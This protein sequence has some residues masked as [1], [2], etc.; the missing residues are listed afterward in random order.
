MEV[1]AVSLSSWEHEILGRIAKELSGSDPKLTSLV[2]GFNRIAATEEMPPR[3]RVAI[4]RRSRRPGGYRH[5]KRQTVKSSWFLMTLWFVTTAALIAVALVLNLF[6]PASGA[7]K[8]CAQP[9]AASCTG[10][11]LGALSVLS[12]RSGS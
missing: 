10:N 6:G 12:P 9:R 11:G 5:K 7:G 2:T 8:D 4:V 3:S 1:A